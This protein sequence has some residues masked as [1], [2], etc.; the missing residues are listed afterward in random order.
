M[1]FFLLV[2]VFLGLTTTDMKD[3]YSFNEG[4]LFFLPDV[5]FLELTLIDMKDLYSFNQ[6]ASLYLNGKSAL[7]LINSDVN[8]E[9]LTMGEVIPG[10]LHVSELLKG[11]TGIG[12]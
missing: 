1:L 8:F 4:V 7:L 10:H 9:R 2:V 3:F 5:V 12:Y 6:D 11:I